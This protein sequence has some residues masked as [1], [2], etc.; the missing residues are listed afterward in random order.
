MQMEWTWYPPFIYF[1]MTTETKQ[2]GLYLAFQGLIKAS[3]EL[4]VCARDN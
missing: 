3:T 1:S 2:L 4:A